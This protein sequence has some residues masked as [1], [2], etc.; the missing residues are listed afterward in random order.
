[1]RF[2]HVNS[3]FTRVCDA[4]WKSGDRFSDK[5]MRKSKIFNRLNR[6]AMQ[7]YHHVSREELP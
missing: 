2:A 7:M 1:M 4:L 6:F 3:A 5:D